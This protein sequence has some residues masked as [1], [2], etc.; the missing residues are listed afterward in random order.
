MVEWYINDHR[1]LEQGFTLKARP[2]YR[3]G[4]GL[5]QLQMKATGNLI[6]WV[7]KEGK[8]IIFRDAQGKEVLRYSGLYAYDAAGKALGARMAADQEGIRLIVEDHE[9]V[10]PITIDPFI[11]NKK[12]L[13]GDGTFDD[14]FGVSVS[15][16]GDTAIVGAFF[17]QDNGVNSGSAYIFS[18]DEGGADN[19][20]EVEKLTASDGALNA[21]FGNSVSIS[22]DTAI[23]GAHADDDNG[24][25]SG[26][27]YIFRPTPVTVSPINHD[28]G[29]VTID[30]TPTQ[31]FTA[32]N[33]QDENLQLGTFSITGLD[34]AEF[35]IQNDTCSGQTLAP[36]GT[37]TFDVLFDP[38]SLGS[39]NAAVSIPFTEPGIDALE[40]GLSGLVT[41][42]CEGDFDNDGD[43]DG[44][45]L[46]VFAEDFGRTDCG[47]GEPC[48]G[49]FDDDNDVDGSDLA[50][51]A[52]DFGRTDCPDCPTSD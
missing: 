5:L 36:D 40:V 34:S 8:G 26:S 52:A 17:D 14:Y 18:R 9:A 50:V 23:V 13:A 11:E 22:G 1:G 46:A 29:I 42:V 44:S 3:R 6:P 32:T 30:C 12:L 25:F 51:F 38:D 7:E 24:R 16:S 21:F 27:A 45:D 48:E 39:K 15:I 4:S 41:E 20:G 43:V 35:L 49:D 10:Y 31:A 33:E 47:T 37:C 28:F 19:W 2:S